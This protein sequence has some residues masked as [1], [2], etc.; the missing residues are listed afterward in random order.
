MCPKVKQREVTLI[1]ELQYVRQTQNHKNS[2]N[3]IAKF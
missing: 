3:A 2:V 1:H